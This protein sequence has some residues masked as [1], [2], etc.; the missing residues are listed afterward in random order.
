M[1]RKLQFVF[2]ERFEQLLQSL[3]VRL[4]KD[5]ATEVIKEALITLDWVTTQ[6]ENGREVFAQAREARA[7]VPYRAA[8]LPQLTNRRAGA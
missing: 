5:T 2:N 1:S 8:T 6:H 4:G 7:A 3:K